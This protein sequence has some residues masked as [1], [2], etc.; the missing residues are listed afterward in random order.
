MIN[1]K[2]KM[3]KI[4]DRGEKSNNL[5]ESDK[6]IKNRFRKIQIIALVSFSLM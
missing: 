5:S 4:E 1:I 6:N 2:E 3:K